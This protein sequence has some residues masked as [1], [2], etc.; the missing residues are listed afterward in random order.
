MRPFFSFVLSLV[1]LT[2]APAAAQAPDSVGQPRSTSG[3]RL[4]LGLGTFMGAGSLLEGAQR[5]VGL[6]ANLALRGAEGSLV[7]EREWGALQGGDYSASTADPTWLLGPVAGLRRDDWSFRLDWQPDAWP[8]AAFAGFGF[9]DG[10][11]PSGERYL[12]RFWLV[13][14]RLVGWQGL[15]LRGELRVR[16]NRWTEL[17]PYPGIPFVGFSPFLGGGQLQR[18]RGS[19]LRMGVQWAPLRAAASRPL[20]GGGPGREPCGGWGGAAVDCLPAVE[21]GA[22]PFMS[23]S[24]LTAEGFAAFGVQAEVALR[25]QALG[26]VFQH[27]WAGLYDATATDFDAVAPTLGGPA[28]W[29]RTDPSEVAKRSEYSVRID[30]AIPGTSSLTG[31]VGGGW[32]SGVTP[33]GEDFVTNFGLAGVRYPL[34]AGAALQ[35]EFRVRGRRTGDGPCRIGVVDGP[36]GCFRYSGIELRLGL[37]WAMRLVYAP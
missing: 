28:P 4:E 31:F 16:E 25:W 10:E 13:G 35:G 15:S 36:D 34:G 5:A 24:V 8:A 29:N 1:L 23:R 9:G 20:G 32:G 33:S 26:V 3:P 27:E 6:T 18:A 14:V 19:E 11:I 12:S 21:L 22:A 2:A 7:V 30:H 17:G 37:R